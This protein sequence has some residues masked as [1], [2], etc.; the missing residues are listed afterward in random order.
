MTEEVSHF[1]GEWTL[2][3][4]EAFDGEEDE[5]ATASLTIAT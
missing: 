2:D 3:N 4:L 1:G 5:T